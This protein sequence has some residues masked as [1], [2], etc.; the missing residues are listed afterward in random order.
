MVRYGEI[1]RFVSRVL[2]SVHIGITLYNESSRSQNYTRFIH[3]L[4]LIPRQ[5]LRWE[6]IM[7]YQG[8]IIL[9]NMFVWMCIF[10]ESFYLHTFALFNFLRLY[11]YIECVSCT[12]RHLR[13]DF[14]V[15]LDCVEQSGVI[16][17]LSVNSV[18]FYVLYLSDDVPF[19]RKVHMA[20]LKIAGRDKK[21][22]V[23]EDRDSINGDKNEKGQQQVVGG[24]NDGGVGACE[25]TKQS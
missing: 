25:E 1:I 12:V 15:W 8:M 14:P 20:V 22:N 7:V 10:V 18:L 2:L 17:T 6:L 9:L 19:Y 24:R 11:S 5:R 16:L 3:G 13:T 21:I 4:S 23:L